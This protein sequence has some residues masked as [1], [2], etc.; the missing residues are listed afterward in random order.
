MRRVADFLRLTPA[1]G[2]AGGGGGRAEDMN[3]NAANAL[4]KVLEEPPPRAVLLLVCSAAGRADADDPQPVPR[5]NLAPLGEDVVRIAAGALC[6]GGSRGCG[7][8]LR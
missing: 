3:R 8:G 4:L 2:L 5:L 6:G 1:E 7:R